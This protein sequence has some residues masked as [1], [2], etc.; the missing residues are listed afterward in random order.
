MSLLDIDSLSPLAL[1]SQYYVEKRGTGHFLSREEI[2][3]IEHW[4][5]LAD[6]NPNEVIV[7]LEEVLQK[8][9]DKNRALGFKSFSAKSVDKKITKKLSEKQL[10]K[11]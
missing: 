7:L 2:S 6:G 9:L 10:L 8:K 4:I 5:L 1:V 3:I 11:N